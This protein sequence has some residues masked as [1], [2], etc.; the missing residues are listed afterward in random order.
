VSRYPRQP[1]QAISRTYDIGAAGDLISTRA[2]SKDMYQQKE[3]NR[4]RTKKIDLERKDPVRIVADL[5]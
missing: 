3:T 1:Y 2:L 4:E 5:G